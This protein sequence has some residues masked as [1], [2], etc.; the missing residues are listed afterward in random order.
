M[1][2]LLAE[3][4]LKGHFYFCMEMNETRE[5]SSLDMSRDR[6]GQDGDFTPESPDNHLLVYVYI[7]T[8]RFA[9]YIT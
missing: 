5:S 2:C 3:G 1:R 8:M 7:H 9:E 6:G 4:N